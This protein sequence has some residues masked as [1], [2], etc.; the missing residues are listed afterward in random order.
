MSVIV[1]AGAT[2]SGK[3]DLALYLAR[4][5]RK[6]G[7]N[8]EF[9]CADSVTVYRGFD[10][11]AAKPSTSLQAEF[12][13]HLLDVANADE[14]FTAGDFVRL[15]SSAI[16]EIGKRGAIPLIVGGTGFYIRA[17]L[18][19]MASSET[20][21][22]ELARCIKQELIDRASQEGYAVLHEELIRLD[23]GSSKTVHPNDHYRVIRALQA[24]RLYGKP[25]SELNQKARDTSFRFPNTRFFCL[26]L[27]KELLK[28][29]VEARTKTMLES[30]LLFEVTSLLEKGVPASA[31]PMQS[32]GYKECVET[33]SG[34]FSSD[35]LPSRIQQATMKLAKQQRTWFRGEAGVEWLHPPFEESLLSLLEQN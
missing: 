11:G 25:W 2:A 13:H 12:P 4:H 9:I 26:D 33:L 1:I 30:G 31:K 20:E 22:I 15:A 19:G 10:I 24:M 5:F 7:K 35:T 14:E 27:Q 28:V 34:Q 23:P 3:S 21:N 32:I 17:L 29:R 16:E 8:T 6:Q 18:R